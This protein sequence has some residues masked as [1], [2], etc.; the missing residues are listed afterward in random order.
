MT[1]TSIKTP[2]HDPNSCVSKLFGKHRFFDDPIEDSP[3]SAVS[4]S[5]VQV[6]DCLKFIPDI[7][8][9]SGSYSRQFRKDSKTFQDN[10]GSAPGQRPRPLKMT[11]M[12]I[13]TPS[14]RL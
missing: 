5:Q 4:Y 9:S 7:K 14:T 13:K 8:F 1:P 6:Q 3:L 10:A 12:S 2:Q 11:P